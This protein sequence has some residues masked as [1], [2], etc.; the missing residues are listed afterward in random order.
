MTDDRVDIRNCSWVHEASEEL[1]AALAKQAAGGERGLVAVFAGSDRQAIERAAA[2]L[3]ERVGR[4]LLRVDLSGLVSKYVG[5]TEKSLDLVLAAADKS[6]AMLFFDE[7]DAL[8]G[9]EAADVAVDAPLLDYLLRRRDA[10]RVPMVLVVPDAAVVTDGARE[11]IDGV[12]SFPRA[13]CSGST[14]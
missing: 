13:S 1:L 11:R 12:L 9:R 7:A 4:S 5:E 3:A 6:A 14:A 10:S 2:T 8:F